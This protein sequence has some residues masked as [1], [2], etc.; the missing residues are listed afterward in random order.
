MKHKIFPPAGGL[1][2]LS[3]SALGSGGRYSFWVR[4]QLGGYRVTDWRPSLGGVRLLIS[5]CLRRPE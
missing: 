1:V 4:S 5:I 2:A 3:G